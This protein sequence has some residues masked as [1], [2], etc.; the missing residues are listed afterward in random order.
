MR[1]EHELSPVG[2]QIQA[3]H[4]VSFVGF[5]SPLFG[6]LIGSQIQKGLPQKLEGLKRVAEQ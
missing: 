6:R 2:N 5:L 3:L 4:R 1:F